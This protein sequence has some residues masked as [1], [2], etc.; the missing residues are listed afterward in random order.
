[1]ITRTDTSDMLFLS[2]L[3]LLICL[4]IVC[5]TLSLSLS[6]SLS[7]QDQGRGGEALPR[8]RGHLR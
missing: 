5:L 6:L 3:P 4:C 7:Q 2:F 8:F 1:M